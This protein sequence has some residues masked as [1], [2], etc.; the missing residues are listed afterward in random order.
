M[1]YQY[2]ELKC[3]QNILK[4]FQMIRDGKL[5]KVGLSNAV[6]FIKNEIAEISNIEKTGLSKEYLE[7]LFGGLND[8][9]FE[10]LVANYKEGY[11]NS[12]LLKNTLLEAVRGISLTK[13]KARPHY[14]V[15]REA[16]TIPHP[17][18]HTHVCCHIILTTITTI[19]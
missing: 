3:K 2:A 4:V 14:R 12:Q 11:D 9:V 17:F 1:R 19:T 5:S 7:F 10:I 16:I 18:I 6:E 13:V 8:K 15:D